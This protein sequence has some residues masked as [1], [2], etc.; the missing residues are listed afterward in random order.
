MDL[1]LYLT[2]LALRLKD[3]EFWID[4]LALQLFWIPVHFLK[5]IFIVQITLPQAF[6]AASMGFLLN[7]LLGG[8]CGKF[9][10]FMR[11]RLLK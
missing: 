6:T 3:K 2:I 11:R 4:T 7:L 1:K 9:L 5:D 10:N 8:I